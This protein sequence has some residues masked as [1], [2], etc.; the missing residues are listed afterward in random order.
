MKVAYPK[1]HAASRRL[2]E[3]DAPGRLKV[4]KDGLD[5]YDIYGCARFEP[6]RE[7]HTKAST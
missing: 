6:L 3:V 7:G 4:E 2:I 5:V 1:F